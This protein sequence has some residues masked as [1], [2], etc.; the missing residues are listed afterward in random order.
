[1][2]AVEAQMFL[3][4]RKF[5]QRATVEIALYSTFCQI[6]DVRWHFNEY[7]L[8][9]DFPMKRYTPLGPPP[10]HNSPDLLL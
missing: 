1:L 3:F 6:A 4:E 10:N 8:S 7:I 9:N 5:K 2:A